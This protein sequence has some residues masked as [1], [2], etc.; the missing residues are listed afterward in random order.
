MLISTEPDNIIKQSRAR[1]GRHKR[2]S[3]TEY[4]DVSSILNISI[5]FSRA[6]KNSL[7]QLTANLQLL[8]T[9]LL[10]FFSNTTR[11]AVPLE[12]REVCPEEIRE[13][14]VSSRGVVSLSLAL[15]Q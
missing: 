10:N 5:C 7:H 14:G 3:A 15:V 12:I 2:N 4:P 11:L 1:E 9:Y 8:A 6:S 13:A